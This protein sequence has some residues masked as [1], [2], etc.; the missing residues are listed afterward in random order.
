M[1]KRKENNG[2]RIKG[3]IF[4]V[5]EVLFNGF[6][7]AQKPISQAVGKAI[8]NIELYN[9]IWV[10]KFFLGRI[11][12]SAMW[13]GVINN[14]GWYITPEAL[15][16]IVRESFTEVDGTRDIVVELR[17]SVRLCILSVHGKEWVEYLKK[18]TRFTELFDFTSFSFES[19]LMKPDPDAFLNATHVME[20][21]PEEC[22]L[23]DD[24]RENVRVARELGFIA[25]R[26]TEAKALRSFLR[27]YGLIPYSHSPSY[28]SRLRN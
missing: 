28:F 18:K 22:I 11:S 17:P 7:L 23:V 19:G 9:S 24:N 5:G 6:Y 21:C 27:E 12:E 26:F 3:V 16:G 10:R 8:N 13:K 15:A 14:F 1:K 4:D 25:H 20:M 2:S